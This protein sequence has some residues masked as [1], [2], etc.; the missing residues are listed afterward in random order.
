MSPDPYS[1]PEEKNDDSDP[2][3]DFSEVWREALDEMEW[4]MTKSTFQRHLAGTSARRDGETLVAVVRPLSIDW[5]TTRFAELI[6]RT[7]AQVAGQQVELRFEA[8]S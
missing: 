6:Q 2:L 8:M 5:L 4:Q 1:Y 3:P 7:V